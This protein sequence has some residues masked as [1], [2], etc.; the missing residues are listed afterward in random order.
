MSWEP[1]SR[2]V[3]KKPS[4]DVR[5]RARRVFHF[6][7]LFVTCLLVANALVGER[8]LVDTFKARQEYRT[9]AAEIARWRAENTEL[10]ELARRLSDD[11]AAIEEIARRE[12]GLIKPGELVF[13]LRDASPPKR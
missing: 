10:R 8:G 6:L 4:A 7:L 13:I 11:P 9:L 5:P 3:R 2:G 1:L 12:L